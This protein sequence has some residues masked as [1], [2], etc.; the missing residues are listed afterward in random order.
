MAESGLRVIPPLT[1]LVSPFIHRLLANLMNGV[2]LE[3]GLP[4]LTKPSGPPPVWSSSRADR[5]T[6]P[7]SKGT[8]KT[9]KTLKTPGFVG[10]AGFEG[11]L[12]HALRSRKNSPP[13]KKALP[14]PPKPPIPP[15]GGV[16]SP[17]KM[18]CQNRQ[19]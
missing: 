5:K 19:N 9:N 12:E 2:P 11:S 4:K 13:L 8:L 18:N 3:K 6:L 16:R 17:L 14:K 1:Y 7:L 10:F 15:R